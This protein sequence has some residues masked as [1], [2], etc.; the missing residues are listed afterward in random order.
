MTPQRFLF[1]PFLILLNSYSYSQILNDSTI[2]LNPTQV[3]IIN[4]AFNQLQKM[5]E[6]ND[7]KDTLLTLKEKRIEILKFQLDTRSN[8]LIEVNRDHMR[9]EK[10]NRRLKFQLLCWKITA[11]VG[12]ITTIL[13]F[14]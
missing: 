1:L 3:K 13:I 6:L 4:L 7:T 9:L 12:I 8:Q 5:N 10:A 11:L 2:C 14:K